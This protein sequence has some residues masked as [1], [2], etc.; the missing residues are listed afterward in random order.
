MDKPILR[1]PVIVEGKYDKIKLDSLFRGQ[2]FPL[3]GFGVFKDIEKRA[4]FQKLAEKTPLIVLTDPDGGGKVL[5]RFL[6]GVLPPERVFH[7]HIPK[8]KGKE[9]RKKA[10]SKEG[11]LGVEGMDA[12]I[13]R[14][15]FA[16]YLLPADESGTDDAFPVP[17][18][19]SGEEMY[20]LG[21]S[22]VPGAAERRAALCKAAGLPEDL[23]TPALR[24]T[25]PLLFSRVELQSMLHRIGI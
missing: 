24:R 19:L 23:T 2:I 17:P 22:G 3:D 12:E 21:L 16:P 7:L 20:A 10:P 11:T 13:L 8:K 4:F 25:L 9:A 6:S 15:L 5:R 14:T 18:P 1:Y